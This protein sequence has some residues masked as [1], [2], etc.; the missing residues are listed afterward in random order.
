MSI[1]SE[2]YEVN[3]SDFEG[4][5]DAVADMGAR[6][7]VIEISSD[8]LLLIHKSDDD[9][10]KKAVEVKYGKGKSPYFVFT[11]D[12][13][14][15][16]N[17]SGKSFPV[18]VVSD[19]TFTPEMTK[20][21]DDTTH[22]AAKINGEK[23]AVSSLAIPT[24]MQRA[25]MSGTAFNHQDLEMNELLAHAIM[26]P[27]RTKN[28]MPQKLTVIYREMEEH[29]RVYKKI[30]AMLGKYYEFIPQTILT[31]MA[32]KLLADSS[33]GKA[34]V[35]AW[36]VNH[37]RTWIYLEFPE[38]ADDITDAYSLPDRFIPGLYLATSDIG[39]NSIVARGTIRQDKSSTYSITE[40]VKRKHSGEVDEN[41]LLDKV[42]QQIFRNVR[43]L[44]E[45]LAKLITVS[46][47]DY[48]G[49][50]MTDEAVQEEN[51]DKVVSIM[52]KVLKTMNGI[53]SKKVRA[54]I[55]EAL[56]E[57]VNPQR[58]YSYYDIAV[59]FMNLGDRLEGIS[60]DTSAFREFQRRCANVPFVLAKEADKADA[61]SADD[62]DG[63]IFLI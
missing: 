43:V 15:K 16:H 12:A 25:G 14:E 7:H 48:A 55:T 32:E 41:D 39:D 52:Q 58:R 8:D 61:P 28:G 46:V 3:G 29:G 53:F 37:S 45:A 51:S 44:P 5:R 30:F 56:A 35:K 23:Y 4:F 27:S 18:G 11:L 19:D 54:G 40:E 33:L 2:N 42:D 10:L 17:R 60:K 57:E 6:T 26:V 13:L 9:E 20:E 34:D 47:M 63:E 36:N 62:E 24:M 21:L 31:R 50:D 1:L 59:L 49:K 22:L 38:A